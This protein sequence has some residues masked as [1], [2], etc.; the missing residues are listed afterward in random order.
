MESSSA[1]YLINLH[2]LPI[3]RIFSCKCPI[4]PINTRLLKPQLSRPTGTPATP[5]SCPPVNEAPQWVQHTYGI[6]FL[7]SGRSDDTVGRVTASFSDVNTRLLKPQ[8]SRPIGTPATPRSC[9][10]VRE[11]PQW[12]QHTYG[13][14][15]L[16]PGRVDDTVGRA[17]S[18]SGVNSRLLKPQLS[19]PT[20]TAAAPRSCPPVKEAPQWVQH[21]YG[22]V[23]LVSGRWDDTVGRVT[24]SFS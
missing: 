12:V 15:F 23:F 8:L 9:P 16:P 24:A 22:I 1:T 7:V 10:P 17:A 6:V 21:T 4:T 13:I 20:G 19:R 2:L 5:R 3:I 14:V 18:F 11:A